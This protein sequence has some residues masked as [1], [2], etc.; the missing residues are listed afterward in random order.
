MMAASR[1]GGDI[2]SFATLTFFDWTIAYFGVR[3]KPVCTPKSASS[4]ARVL[5]I[6]SATPAAISAGRTRYRASRFFG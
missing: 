3:A 2:C 1:C 6:V 5:M 4:T